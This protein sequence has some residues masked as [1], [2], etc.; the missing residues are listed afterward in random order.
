[1][2]ITGNELVTKYMEGNP[3][4]RFKLIYVHYDRF[5]N[6]V[7]SFELGVFHTILCEK[8][9]NNQNRDDLGVKVQT[10]NLSDITAEEAIEHVMIR[11]AIKACDFSGD[12]LKGTDDAEKHKVEIRAIKMMRREYEIFNS[13]LE[14]LPEAEYRI[15]HKYISKACKLQQIA[16]DEDKAYQT[17]KNVLFSTRKTLEEDVVPFLGKTRINPIK[18]DFKVG[19]IEGLATSLREEE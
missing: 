15:T 10:S 9:Y 1:M 13:N 8:E 5:L 16:I 19:I 3:H 6:M 14:S 7:E 2:R 12:L 11:D 4:D 18:E 17:I